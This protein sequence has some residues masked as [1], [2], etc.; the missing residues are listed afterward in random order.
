MNKFFF[1]LLVAYVCS[2]F[3]LSFIPTHQIVDISKACVD[4]IP[5]AISPN[6][7]GINDE[8]QIQF[9]CKIGAYSLEIYDQSQQLI[10]LST[11]KQESWDGLIEGEPAPEGYYSWILRYRSTQ[12]SQVEREEGELALVR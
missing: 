5:G 9:S 12:D 3:T 1:T 6:G 10:H 7:D 4:F 8:F 11:N 2:F